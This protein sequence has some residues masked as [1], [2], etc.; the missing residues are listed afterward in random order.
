[1]GYRFKKAAGPRAEVPRVVN[2]RIQ[3]AIEAL[4]RYPAEDVEGLHTARKDI[5]KVRSL[6]R[7]LREPELR[8]MRKAHNAELRET[9]AHLSAHRDREVLSALMD[10]WLELPEVCHDLPLH[11]AVATMS[12]TYKSQGET[13]PPLD[14]GTEHGAIKSLN[15]IAVSVAEANLKPL[16]WKTIKRAAR[17]RA[18]RM[19]KAREAYLQ[20]PETETLHEW[21]KQVKNHYHHLRLLK[22][23]DPPGKGRL[24][25]VR[26]LEKR[27]GNARDLD[28][29]LD[30]L[31]LADSLPLGIQEMG[32]L[33]A[34]TGFRK[35][36]ILEAAME[37][38]RQS[39]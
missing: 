30:S 21:R 26:L 32:S 12:E 18:R 11:A 31:R 38:D 6:L 39:T 4:R 20:K 16:S 35:E 24:R 2:E 19:R 22:K 37:E 7:L 23:V 9:A 13:H 3:H 15:R 36:R 8:N 25:Q 14:P 17:K 5:K 10:D 34:Y 33:L 27:L 29:L 1:M 28:L